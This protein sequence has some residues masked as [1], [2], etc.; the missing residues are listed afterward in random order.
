MKL[1]HGTGEAAAKIILRH[2]LAPR[3]TKKSKWTMASGKDRVYLTTAYPMYFSA[4]TARDGERWAVLEIDTDKLD[5]THLVPDEDFLEQATRNHPGIV[6]ARLK[7]MVQ[8]TA[9]FRDN[10]D[11]FQHMWEA[12]LTYLGTCAYQGTIPPSAIRRV[13][14]FAPESNRFIA[15]RALDPTI[16]LLNY[17]IVGSTYRALVQWLF[18]GD[19]TPDAVL[20]EHIA[21]HTDVPG[22]VDALEAAKVAIANRSGVEV[23]VL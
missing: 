17:K 20:G 7:T 22:V 1:Y 19:V 13:A 2:G 14:Y 18:D 8:R 6:P 10:I 4:N 23:K 21:S 9:W 11:R 5:S 15:L 3:G 12:S 16:S